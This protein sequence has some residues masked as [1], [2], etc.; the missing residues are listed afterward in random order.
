MSK[1]MLNDNM[2]KSDE[3]LSVELDLIERLKNSLDSEL[4]NEPIIYNV[5]W[6]YL[7]D[8]KSKIINDSP[9]NVKLRSDIA[10]TFIKKEYKIDKTISSKR[11]NKF[12][13]DNFK[14][15]IILRDIGTAYSLLNLGF[16]KESVIISG[17]V[18]EEILRLFLSEKQIRCSHNTFSEYIKACEN[19]NLFKTG[20]SR[21]SDFVR[22]FRNLVHLQREKGKQDTVNISIA[23]SAVS[24]I[25]AIIDEIH[26]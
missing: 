24:S 8:F 16:Y 2:L 10:W 3:T 13:K 25:F 11:L 4:L 12:I 7:D 21:L 18:I 17:G 5:I 14:R 1:N 6:T 26:K 19:N 23:K 20:I 15:R 22:E 9:K